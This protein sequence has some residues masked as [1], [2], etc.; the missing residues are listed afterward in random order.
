ML[1]P[2][3]G[4]NF[5]TGNHVLVRRNSNLG[6]TGRPSRCLYDMKN[7]MTSWNPDNLILSTGMLS[8]F[9]SALPEGEDHQK[10]RRQWGRDLNGGWE[11]RQVHMWT[12]SVRGGEVAWSRWLSMA[13]SWWKSSGWPGGS[14]QTWADMIML[15]DDHCDSGNMCGYVA[16]VAMMETGGSLPKEAYWR[17][18]LDICN[19]NQGVCMYE[20]RVNGGWFDAPGLLTLCYGQ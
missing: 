15:L 14:W 8:C 6:G 9:L 1:T 16:W 11:R 19:W 4:S 13:L 3:A 18:P 7:F 12:C 17:K 5:Y 10:E 2:K 20:W